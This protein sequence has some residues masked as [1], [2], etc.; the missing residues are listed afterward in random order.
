MVTA[1]DKGAVILWNLDAPAE[2]ARLIN[3][4]NQVRC[5]AFSPDGNRLATACDDK[6]VRVWDVVGEPRLLYEFTQF[7]HLAHHVSFSRDGRKLGVAIQYRSAEII[8]FDHEPPEVKTIPHLRWVYTVDFSPD[9]ELIATACGDQDVHLWNAHTGAP[10]RDLPHAA[11]ITSAIFSQ[12]GK[13]LI[14]SARDGAVHIWNI[15]RELGAPLLLP[16]PENAQWACS[17]P[18]GRWIAGGG[19]RKGVLRVWDRNQHAAFDEASNW[20]PVYGMRNWVALPAAE[21]RLPVPPFRKGGPKPDLRPPSEILG[22]STDEQT[23]A[24][25]VCSKNG[26]GME[27]LA[28]TPAGTTGRT[29]HPGPLFKVLDANLSRGLVMF[30]ESETN[31]VVADAIS[32]QIRF[33]DSKKDT[34]YLDGH[35]DPS[36]RWATI[37][38]KKECQL[39][40]LDSGKDVVVK[41]VSDPR[42]VDPYFHTTSAFSPDGKLL[43]VGGC[44]IDDVPCAGLVYKMTE[45]G[46]VP[47]ASARMCIKMACAPFHFPRIP[48]RW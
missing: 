13:A 36:G 6:I 14:A 37:A 15:R 31:V 17:S 10:V 41:T 12:D 4:S 11:M 29:L 42:P 28:R 2:T 33:R 44:S 38:S 25:V 32:G 21:K 22:Y 23:G 1:G 48:G 34:Q 7:K 45:A 26:D 20:N 18:D 43:C 8:S 35:F 16:H 46:P 9:G 19:T 24:Y 40:D 30:L 47:D 5:A 27:V 39:L 3:H